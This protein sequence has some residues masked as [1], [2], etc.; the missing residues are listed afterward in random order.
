MKCRSSHATL[1]VLST[2]VA[3]GFLTPLRAQAQLPGSGW[4]LLWGDEFNGNRLDPVKWNTAYPW[5]RVHNYPAYIDDANITVGGGTLNLQAKRQ[6]EGGQPYTS[7]AINS[8]GLFNFHTGYIEASMQLP[9]WLG[10]WPAFWA[11]QDGWPPELDVMEARF[12]SSY[13]GTTNTYDGYGDMYSYI[14]TYH[15]G[16][17]SSPPSAGTGFVYPG[18]DLTAAFHNYG[19]LWAS[20]HVTFYFDGRAM[21][22]VYSSSADIAQ[23]QNMYLLLNLGVGGWPGDPPS[24][25]DISTPFKV[26]WVRVWQQPGTSCLSSTWTKTGNGNQNWDDATSWSATAP[27]LGSQTAVFGN[28][29]G[30]TT[31]VR[32]DWNHNKTIG[33]LW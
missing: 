14:G 30:S 23:M 2:A 13:N 9:N 16:S 26:D 7:G 12:R 18:G 29:G 28:L 20:D 21:G 3:A 17:G 32:L 33:T 27:G 31:D 24:W 6:S 19:T 22:S 25:A 4:Q 8:N 5:G 1:A 15:W 11:L 10:A